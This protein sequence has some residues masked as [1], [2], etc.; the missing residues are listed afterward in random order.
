MG[1]RGVPAAG[2]GQLCLPSTVVE[3][4]SLL[5]MR[6]GNKIVAITPALRAELFSVVPE[7]MALLSKFLAVLKL[8]EKLQF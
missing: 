1:S 2:L 6:F 4:S 5:D 7:G 3:N 8:M